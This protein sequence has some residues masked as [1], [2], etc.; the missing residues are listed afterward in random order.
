MNRNLAIVAGLG[1]F[2]LLVIALLLKKGPTNYA[3]GDIGSKLSLPSLGGGMTEAET[4]AEIGAALAQA[5]MPKITDAKYQAYAGKGTAAA[6][7]M[8]SL[9]Q[10]DLSAWLAGTP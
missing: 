10:R 5:T 8:Q 2:G 9:F 4:K 1:A 6:T 3:F 7:T